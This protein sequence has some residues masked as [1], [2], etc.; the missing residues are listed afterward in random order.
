[1]TVENC[2]GGRACAKLI[3]VVSFPE[4]YV[5]EQDWSMDGEIW[6]TISSQ[7]VSAAVCENAGSKW[8]PLCTGLSKA[9]RLVWS[10]DL[11]V[12][13][14]DLWNSFSVKIYGK[15]YVTTHVNIYHH[16]HTCQLFHHPWWYTWE[17]TN[18][19]VSSLY[20]NYL[21]C[22]MFIISFSPAPC[23]DFLW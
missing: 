10:P 23:M 18:L 13:R 5:W 15:T 14:K 7:K 19:K 8:G 12:Q 3:V 11:S 6:C 21:D 1:M 17:K 20:V 2:T 4:C 16:T 22:D 9:R